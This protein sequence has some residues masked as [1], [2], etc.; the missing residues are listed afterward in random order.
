MKVPQ[1]RFFKTFSR[2]IAFASFRLYSRLP[3]RF[4]VL[5]LSNDSGFIGLVTL[6]VFVVSVC[7]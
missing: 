3:V 2:F 6:F 4:C 5:P 1:N 7:Q